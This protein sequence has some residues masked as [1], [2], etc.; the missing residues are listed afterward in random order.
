M[1]VSITYPIIL[2]PAGYPSLYPVSRYSL[3]RAKLCATQVSRAAGTARALIVEPAGS[4][5][6]GEAA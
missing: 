5:H 6:L 1:Y 3:S 2:Y 4:L